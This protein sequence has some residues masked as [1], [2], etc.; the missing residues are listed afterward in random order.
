MEDNTNTRTDFGDY[1]SGVVFYEQNTV[2][3]TNK[4]R[5]EKL[6]TIEQRD[7]TS[8]NLSQ[9]KSSRKQVSKRL[10]MNTR[11]IVL[12]PLKD[13]H[14][15]SQPTLD[16]VKINNKKNSG[17]LLKLSHERQRTLTRH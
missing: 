9:M 3:H 5:N 4:K 2:G 8:E 12:P 14:V 16:K 11:V 17:S 10:T 6:D 1:A 15:R 13:R 7:D